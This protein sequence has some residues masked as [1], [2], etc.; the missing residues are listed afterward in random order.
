M[1]LG[2]ASS[3]VKHDV[4]VQPELT[5]SQYLKEIASMGYECC[6][7]FTCHGQAGY[8]EYLSRRDRKELRALAKDLGLE[9]CGIGAYGGMLVTT[10]FAY[11]V[12]E[13]ERRYVVNYMKKCVDLAV[14][15]D[16]KVVEDISGMKP[17][18]IREEQAWDSLCKCLREIS[19]Y[20]H[21][22]SVYLAIEHLGLVDTPK[23]FLRLADELRSEA[24]KCVYD[25]SNMLKYLGQTKKEIL[26]GISSNGDYIADVHLKGVSKD[27]QFV[28]PCSDID[29]YGQG[30]FLA[31]LKDVE[32]HDAVIV[33]E[34]EQLYVPSTPEKPFSAARIARKDVSKMLEGLKT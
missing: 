25:P 20:A 22:N 30:D 28:R 26:E 31:A 6:E 24:L 12:N 9:I 23:K 32:Y 27:L 7:I 17:A 2:Y 13:H 5:L 18:G 15:L 8:P 1:K 4:L 14:D 10:E 16:S 33:E 19:D 11:L 21:D 34:F 29:Y 3:I